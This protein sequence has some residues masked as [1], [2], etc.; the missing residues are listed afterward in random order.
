MAKARLLFV[1]NLRLLMIVLVIMAHLSITYGGEGGWYYKEGRADTFTSVLLTWFNATCQ[2]FFMGFL[3]LLSGYFTAGAYERKGP[4]KFS[5]DRLLRLGIPLLA[6]DVVLH[7]L[8]VCTLLKSGIEGPN[9]SCRRWL[10]EYYTSF[11]LGMGPLWFVEALLI[12]GVVYLL[13]QWL[14]R[15]KAKP[16]P[17]KRRC[18]GHKE[19]VTL[20]LALGVA[21]FIIRIWLPLGWSIESLNLQLPF[22]LQYTVLFVLGI[23]AYHHGWLTGIPKETGRPWLA[24]GAVLILVGFPLLFVL[25]GALQGDLEPYKGGLHWQSLAL[26][27]W[28]QATGLAMMAGLLVLFRERLNRQGSLLAEASACS[29]TAYIIHGPFIILYALA[30]RSITLYPLL[31]FALA[32]LIAIPL[33]FV[34]AAGIRRLPAARRIL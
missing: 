30:V 16:A 33:C 12:F 2:S 28:E 20:A 24:I 26:C 17:K 29:Y 21:S 3:F 34:L 8:A 32:T 23:G 11:H 5:K 18:P 22:F 9:A 14:T 7:P 4:W 25:G 1:D 15:A 31:K 13:W 10:G 19:I 6:Y 27:I